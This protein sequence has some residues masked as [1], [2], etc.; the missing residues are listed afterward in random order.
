MY[1]T[2]IINDRDRPPRRRSPR[3]ALLVAVEVSGKDIARSCFNVVTTATNLNRHGAAVHL[4]R[5][6]AV[7]SVIVL[8]NSRGSRT[9]ARIVDQTLAR[10]IYTYGVEFLEAEKTRNFW[11]L[12]F[13]SDPQAHSA[14]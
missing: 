5:D 3:I 8:T 7:E 11:G 1:A 9:S 12:R 4:N 2:A 14:S 13:P 6:L 10:D